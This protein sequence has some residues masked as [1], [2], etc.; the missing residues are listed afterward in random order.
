MVGR[1]DGITGPIITKAWMEESKCL[2]KM[3]KKMWQKTKRGNNNRRYGKNVEYEIYKKGS[4]FVAL[5]DPKAMLD[6]I[7]E[8]VSKIGKSLN[9]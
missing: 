7:N 6:K 2:K 8:M 9:D 5:N 3:K 1:W 4:H